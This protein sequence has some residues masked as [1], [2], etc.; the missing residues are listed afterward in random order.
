MMRRMPPLIFVALALFSALLPLGGTARSFAATTALEVKGTVTAVSA[1][2]LSITSH[3][4]QAMTFRLTATTIYEKNNQPA[5]QA[6]VQV[7][8]DVKVKYHVVANGS[9]KAKKVT[10]EQPTTAIPT[11][12]PQP[13]ATPIPPRASLPP[14]AVYLPQRQVVS[15]AALTIGLKTLPRG[16]ISIVLRVAATHVVLSG[17]GRH[18]TRARHTVVLYQLTRQGTANRHGLF[19]TSVQVTYQPSRPMQATLTVTL[20]TSSGTVARTLGVTIQPVHHRR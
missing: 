15:G 16:Q 2:S 9:L 6:D 17:K 8:L 1:D 19:T 14:L 10:I 18:R 20:R 5:E 4:G 12:T 13:T 7:G 3:S 11:A